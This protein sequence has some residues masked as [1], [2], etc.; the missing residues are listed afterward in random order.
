M[1]WRAEV[2]ARQALR[3]R[4]FYL[5]LAALY[6]VWFGVAALGHWAW[7]AAFGYDP[8]RRDAFAAQTAFAL[9]G[10][11]LTVLFIR[12]GPALPF[13]GKSPEEEAAAAFLE[14]RDVRSDDGRFEHDLKP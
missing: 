9:V 3:R 13:R 5:L 7:T 11:A 12:Y 10:E 2:R 8:S 6:V 4:R 1:N 14:G